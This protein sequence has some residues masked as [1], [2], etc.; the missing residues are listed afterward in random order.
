MLRAY[1]ALFQATGFAFS[2]SYIEDT[3]NHNPGMAQML[4]ELFALRFDPCAGWRPG[5]YRWRPVRPT[6]RPRW[7]KSAAWSKTGSAPVPRHHPGHAAHQRTSPA[8]PVMSFKLSPR[9]MPN[10][11]EPKPLYEIWVYS[12]R[13]EGIHLRGVAGGAGRPALVRPTRR[14][15]HRNPGLVKAQ[16]VK[17]T[18]IV[19]VGPKAVLS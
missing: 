10:V 16:M 19:P 11:P 18:V 9:D 17:N 12:P 13:M 15:P 6:S 5:W 2:Q 8:R 1:I 3:L 14:L 4:S 7:P